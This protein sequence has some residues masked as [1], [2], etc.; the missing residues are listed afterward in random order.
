MNCHLLTK[1]KLLTNSPKYS[2]NHSRDVQVGS[3]GSGSSGVSD[4][5]QPLVDGTGTAGGL[6]HNDDNDEELG[7]DETD[8]LVGQLVD[9]VSDL[10]LLP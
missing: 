7:V 2:G 1:L 6:D 9:Y 5:E 10:A 4:S 3:S 8:E